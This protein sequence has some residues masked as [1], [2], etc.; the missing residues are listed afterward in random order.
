[1]LPGGLSVIGIFACAPS[2]GV[3]QA[4]M[5]LKQVCSLQLAS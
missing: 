1:M 2:E 3:Q 5:K 4:Q